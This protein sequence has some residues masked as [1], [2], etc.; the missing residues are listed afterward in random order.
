MYVGY[1]GSRIECVTPTPVNSPNLKFIRLDSEYLKIP[2]AIIKQRFEVLNGKLLPK[3]TS[4]Q[5]LS[6]YKGLKIAIVSSYGS[7]CGMSTYCKYLITEMKKMVNEIKIFAEI[8]ASLPEDPSVLRCW[9]RAKGTY[10]GVVKE[11]VKFEPDIVY[12]QHEYGSFTNYS[13]WN[14][15]VG[16]LSSLYRTVVVLHSVYDHAAKLVIEAPCR[17]IIVHSALGRDLLKQKG[18]N[19]ALIHYIPHGCI[20]ERSE[21]PKYASMIDEHVIFQYGFGFEYKGWSNVSGIIEELKKEFKEAT[22]IGVF[23][24]SKFCLTQHNDYY[25][26]LMEEIRN[27][28]LESNIV[29]HKGFRSEEILF[30]YM[31]QSR[32]NLFP[33]WNHHDWMVHGAS[34]AVR[35]ALASGTPTVVGNVP[36]FYEFKD[37]LPVC[38]NQE[39]FVA[40]IKKIFKDEA[41][42]FS[43]KQRMKDFIEERSWDKIAAWYLSVDSNAEFT[44]L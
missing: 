40:Q 21:R 29:L 4:E 38:S 34:G 35:L 19:H 13:Q 20:S 14:V 27:R 43:I 10:Y 17:E 9:D 15:L 1:N 33:Y 3:K 30:S 18:V 2:P 22:Y 32:V 39:E 41:Y 24:T 8:D 25:T 16:H 42:A 31:Q 5:N 28:N 36:F 7:N 26:K 44:A 37:Y 23:N 6:S 11:V 12:I